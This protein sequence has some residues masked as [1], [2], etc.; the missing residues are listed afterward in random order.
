MSIILFNNKVL[1]Y[2]EYKIGD[3]ITYNDEEYYVIENSDSSANYVTLLKTK[4]LTIEELY[5]YGRDENDHLFVNEYSL[6]TIDTE[7]D[8]Y[9]FFDG[10]GGMSYYTSDQCKYGLHFWDYDAYTSV[11]GGCTNDYDESDV[12]KVIDNWTNSNFKDGDLVIVDGYSSR[13]ISLDDIQKKLNFELK[14]NTGHYFFEGDIFN[15]ELNENENWVMNSDQDSNKHVWVINYRESFLGTS[16]VLSQKNVRPVINLS[17]CVLGDQD[18][19]CLCEKKHTTKK[20]TKYNS[21]NIGDEI[22]YKGEK[23]YVIQNSSKSK[24]YVTWIYVKFLDTN[25]R[26]IL[27][28]FKFIPIPLLVMGPQPSFIT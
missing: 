26:T 2:E 20:I 8:I 22:E 12:K 15:F 27:T 23:Y 24:N 11:S 7:N 10:S 9:E 1:A 3:K 19:F 14:F 21:Y 25:F 28:V 5:K 17:K 6:Q 18:E 13:I 16:E 4:P